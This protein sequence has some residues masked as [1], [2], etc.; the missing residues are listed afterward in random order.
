MFIDILKLT[1]PIAAMLLIGM[2]AKKWNWFTPEGAKAFRNIVGNVMLPAVLLD[3]FI[4]A[5][6]STNILILGSITLLW[7][8]L[9]LGIGFLLRGVMKTHGKYLPFLVTA[10]E[11]GMLGYSLIAL[12]F[13]T[14]G[15]AT[16]A[17]CDLGHTFFV[18]AIAVPLLLTVTG[19]KT[20]IK[21]VVS[22]IFHSFPFDGMMLGIILGLLGAGRAIDGNPAVSSIYHAVIDMISGPTT[23][24]I[25]IS[26]TAW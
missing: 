2:A 13:G 3:A 18:F 23:A 10:D 1:L 7:M 16:M 21:S 14:T 19:Q 22:G 11:V 24:L 8:L 20:S 17:M 15:V 4:F 6:Y 5:D 25:L 12:L 9:A 26:I